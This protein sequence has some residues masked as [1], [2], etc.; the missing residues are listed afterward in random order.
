M[1]D[2][3]LDAF[4][5]DGRTQGWTERTLGDYRY[6]MQGFLN[7]IKKDPREVDL[8]DLRG[9]LCTID[10]RGLSS[11]TVWKHFAVLASFFDFLEVEDEIVRNPIPK[12]RRRYL[13]NRMKNMD[14]SEPK[15]QIISVNEMRDLVN[16]ILNPRDKAIV[17]V[18]AKTGIRLSELIGIDVEDIDWNLQVISLK[19]NGKRSYLKAF[20]DDETARILRR[21]MIMRD[22]IAKS[23]ERAM[24]INRYG[25]RIKRNGVTDL[26]SRHAEQIGL[27]D[28]NSK[29]L[30]KRFTPHCCGHWFT[31]HLERAGMPEKHIKKL[32]GDSL[33]ETID[34]YNHIGFDEL[35]ESYRT[36]IPQLGV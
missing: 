5:L 35:W 17:L 32:R 20:F 1:N 28:P 21:Y 27:H 23:G 9:Y 12:F 4:M 31:T 22:N 14:N 11:N 10:E 29:D 16:S 13:K 7:H 25:E 33:N 26:V 2:D 30:Q 6:I 18:L 34:I 15:R 8:N 19:R 36:Y 24:F 3:F